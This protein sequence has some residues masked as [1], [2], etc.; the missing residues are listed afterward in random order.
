MLQCEPNILYYVTKFNKLKI[1]IMYLILIVNKY[2]KSCNSTKLSSP[3]TVHRLVGWSP[4]NKP[5]LTLLEFYKY[6]DRKYQD[7]FSLHSGYRIYDKK[8][9]YVGYVGMLFNN[10]S[11]GTLPDGDKRHNIKPS[12]KSL[13]EYITKVISEHSEKDKK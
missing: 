13:K 5:K 3:S 6:L 7:P 2:I 11:N 1:D 10:S 12:V 9:I 8:G 4:V